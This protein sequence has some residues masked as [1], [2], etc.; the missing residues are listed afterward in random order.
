LIL[1][2]A[3]AYI[4]ISGGNIELGAPGNILLKAANVQKMGSSSLDS[5]KLEFPK[6][7]SGGF[8]L[9]DPESGEIK[10]FTKYKITTGEG[11]IF[12]GFSDAAGKTPDIN[13]VAPTSIQVSFPDEIPTEGP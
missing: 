4:K 6:G 2:C 5:P 3:G 9:K 12:E 8:T 1:N 11:E 10:P 7:Y 13:S